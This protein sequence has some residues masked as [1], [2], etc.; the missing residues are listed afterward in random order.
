MMDPSSWV[1]MVFPGLKSFRSGT[2]SGLSDSLSAKPVC[3]KQAL[4]SSR[5]SGNTPTEGVAEISL[6]F[7]QLPVSS[8]HTESAWR[9]IFHSFYLFSSIDCV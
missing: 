6:L 2:S 4:A 3:I 5:Q 9:L 7:L 1:A 8:F